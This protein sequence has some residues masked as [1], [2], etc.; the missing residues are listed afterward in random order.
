MPTTA[1]LEDA[2]ER[3][4]TYRKAAGV[5][6]VQLESPH[7]VDEIKGARRAVT[8]PFSFMKGKLPRYLT[9]DEHL[10]PRVNMPAGTWDS[11][12]TYLNARRHS[13]AFMNVF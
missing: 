9:L 13:R 11:P 12:I 3:L 8:G 7:S 1:G 2:L 5:D 6:W 10:Q 4:E